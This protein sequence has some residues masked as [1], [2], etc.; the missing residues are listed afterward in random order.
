MTERKEHSLKRDYLHWLYCLV[1]SDKLA[2]YTLVIKYLYKKEFYYTHAMDENREA[3]GRV[4][5][6]R[7]IYEKTATQEMRDAIYE[8]LSG[9][10]SVLEVLI[11]LTERMDAELY[12]P[13]VGNRVEYEDSFW[14]LFRNLGLD[15]FT[16]ITYID[17]WDETLLDKKITKFLE[18]RYRKDGE[19]GLFP[20][21]KPQDDQR[22]VEL[23]YQMQAYLIEN[24]PVGE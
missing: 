13:A 14:E 3:D 11:G 10:A 7:Y 23:W 15:A 21:K 18:R 17:E 16:D 19:G 6:D 8:V 20:L 2:A 22:K 9:P 12:L 4:L 1:E 5:R 24:Y